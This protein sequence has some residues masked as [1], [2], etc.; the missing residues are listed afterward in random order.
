MSVTR[1]RQSRESSKR[2]VGDWVG[3]PMGEHVFL[4][5]V[6]E[7]RGPLGPRGKQMVRVTIDDPDVSDRDAF[8]TPVEWLKPAP[9]TLRSVILGVTSVVHPCT[10]CEIADQLGVPLASVVAALERLEARRVVT[11]DVHDSGMSTWASLIRGGALET[12]EAAR[13]RKVTASLSDV[14]VTPYPPSRKLRQRRPPLRLRRP[15]KNRWPATIRVNGEPLDPG[16]S[17]TARPER[18]GDGSL[19]PRSRRAAR[20]YLDFREGG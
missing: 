19:S 17:T 7:D 10:D 12:L 6:V 1:K 18:S 2:R 11:R 8:D 15:A 9:A 16:I 14:L 20:R 4:G 5:H 13:K 3:V